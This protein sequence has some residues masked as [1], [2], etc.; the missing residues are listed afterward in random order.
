[1]PRRQGRAQAPRLR[2]RRR[3]LSS[4]TGG[5]RL[6]ATLEICVIMRSH[7]K[8]EKREEGSQRVASDEEA[9]PEPLGGKPASDALAAPLR[10]EMVGASSIAPRG[11]SHDQ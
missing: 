7:P 11:K 8:R 6:T 5:S 1:M 2:R 9:G 4:P 3:R 10:T